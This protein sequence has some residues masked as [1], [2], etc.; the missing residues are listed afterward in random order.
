[1][2]SQPSVYDEERNRLRLRAWEQRNQETSQAK[3]LTDNVPLFGVPYKRNTGDELSDRIQRMLGSYEDEK[4]TTDPSISVTLLQPNL[5]KP[6]QPPVQDQDHHISSQDN[7]IP[8]SNSYTFQAM[9]DVPAAPSSPDIH[10]DSLQLPK[11]TFDHSMGQEKKGETLPDLREH[12]SNP[13]ERSAQFADVKPIPI[14]HSSAPKVALAK[15]TLESRQESSEGQS[16]ATAVDVSAFNLRQSPADATQMHQAGKGGNS[17]LSQNFPPLS[18]SKQPSVVM[19][20]KPT[21]YVRPTMDGQDQLL[22]GSPELKPSPE[23]YVPLQE[24]R[25]VDHCKTKALHQYLE[26]RE[27]E[28]LRVEDILKEMAHYWPPLLTAIHI[29]NKSDVPPA[30]EAGQVSSCLEL[31]SHDRSSEDSSNLNV[32]SSSFRHKET[33]SSSVESASSSDSDSSSRSDSDSESATEKPRRPPL[34]SSKTETDTAAPSSN[35]D[36]QLVKWIRSSQQNFNNESQKCAKVCKSP[37]DKRPQ[38]LQISKNSNVDTVGESKPPKEFGG[39]PPKAQPCEESS[40]ESFCPKS[41]A[42]VICCTSSKKHSGVALKTAKDPTKTTLSVKCEDTVALCISNKPKLKTKTRKRKN[43]SSDFK[44]STKRTFKGPEVQKTK[45]IHRPEVV[46]RD[47]CCASCGKI[48]PD[49]CSCLPQSLTRLDHPSPALPVEISCSKPNVEPPCHKEAKVIPKAASSAT[50]KSCEKSR[51]FSKSSLDLPNRPI[52]SLLV[53]IDLNLL[54][55]VPQ[56]A[57]MKTE[58]PLHTSENKPEASKHPKAIKKSLP[59]IVEIDDKTLPRKKLKLEKKMTSSNKNSSVKVEG[60]SNRP[61]QQKQNKSKKSCVHLPQPQ[62]NQDCGKYTKVH[63]LSSL[64]T[65][66]DASKSK[67]SKSSRTKHTPLEKKPSTQVLK[68]ATSRPLLLCEDRKYPVKHYIREA[69]RLKHKADAESDKLSKAFNYLDA[70]MFFVES[71]IAMEKDP[72]I[73]MSSYTMFAETVELL[74]FVLKLKN[75]TDSSLPA[76]RKDFVALCLKC[77]ALLQMAMFR[78][79]HETA[80]KY[81][82]TLT[83][84][85]S[86]STLDPS[87]CATNGPD[88]PSSMASIPSPACGVTKQSGSAAGPASSTV[89]VPLAV[90]QVALS[91]VNITT[92]VL[93][94]HDL[95]EQAE[96]MASKGSGVLA[97]LDSLVGPL[98]L[99][100]SVSFMVRYTRQG[101]LWLRTDSQKR[102]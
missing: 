7:T 58:K 52:K 82:K 102:K 93:S 94:A 3:E 99:T 14:L 15:D 20:Q 16:A 96:E 77:Q 95:W 6:G 38:P 74:K 28:T 56:V 39:N 42:D 45:S 79:K 29:S 81:S 30:K 4:N 13:Q 37:T 87:V 1:M 27:N 98:S 101:V 2:A 17:L 70:A 71:G 35:V 63:K 8:P 76:S 10:R 40:C 51:R 25:K 50:R 9:T 88:T 92:L 24:I 12:A 41:A 100:S 11:G 19:T 36:W 69:K 61:D 26:T 84:H 43:K 67:D 22:S 48:L 57:P 86:S 47:A 32:Q 60:C 18:S 64:E 91:Y 83:D 78:Q 65:H 23:S 31:K 89:C 46:Q 5:D 68:Q 66:K 49:T 90:E 53:K 75:S 59:Q 62:K 54:S 21:A 33:Y 72:Q 80:L 97:K 34:S 85:F 55:R 44:S 73:S